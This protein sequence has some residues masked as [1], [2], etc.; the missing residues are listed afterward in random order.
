MDMMPITNIFNEWW[1][2]TTSKK[3]RA[4]R[5]KNAK[6]GKNGM[7]HAPYGYA[8]GT[9]EKRTLQVNPETAPVVRRIFE[10]RASGMTPRKIAETFN[11]EGI[12]CAGRI[13]FL[14]S[15]RK[16]NNNEHPYWEK[17]PIRPILR[18]I[19]YLGHMAQQKFTSVSYKNHKKYK[20]DQS[21]WVITYNNHEPII[22]QE[23]WDKVQA[24]RKSVARGRKTK[25][26]FT[27]PLPGFLICADRGCKMKMNTL[28]HNNKRSYSFNCG[29]H[30]RFG[31]ALCFSHHIM[32]KDIEAVI[33]DDIRTMA[34][35][36]ILDE[37]AI[38]KE[39]LRHNAE[40]K[41]QTMRS[42]KKQL[43]TKRKR[44]EELSRL[45]QTAYEDR[46]NGK[47]PED[48]CIGFIQKYSAEQKTLATE[49][50]ELETKLNEAETV[51]QS[52]DEFIR[53]I[54]KYLEA[55]TLTRE[56]CYELIERVIVGG[57]PKYTGKDREITI[58]YKVDIASV[59]RHRLDK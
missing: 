29:G 26:G 17:A 1:A 2:A 56:M 32:A 44:T 20:K 40:L 10:M 12:P 21:D 9:D 42:I 57:H 54:K 16:Y 25:I 31:K 18:N 46:V 48:I 58:V 50:A 51:K 4:V 15:G 45:M 27:H 37:E 41:D 7:S 3:L 30:M 6:E 8:L 11:E 19:A 53:N 5:I 36:I 49:I 38:K 28:V 13:A 24:R 33:L 35:R 23:L 59:L 47:M 55:P 43:Q 39:F 14:R 34:Q 52:A 22:S